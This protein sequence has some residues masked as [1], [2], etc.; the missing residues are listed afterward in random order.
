MRNL[1]LVVREILKLYAAG[2]I[3]GYQ[4]YLFPQETIKPITV[5]SMM[6]SKWKVGGLGLLF[7]GVIKVMNDPMVTD[8]QIGEGVAENNH[9]K[10]ELNTDFYKNRTSKV[11]SISSIEFFHYITFGSRSKIVDDWSIYHQLDISSLGGKYNSDR[12]RDLLA[13]INECGG[14]MV[15]VVERLLKS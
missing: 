15:A 7:L 5:E 10:D 14:D 9:N 13:I 4:S 1:T 3:V 12:M 11:L 2:N 6:K 8:L